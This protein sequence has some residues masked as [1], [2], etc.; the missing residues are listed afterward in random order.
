MKTYAAIYDSEIRRKSSSGGVFTVLASEILKKNGVVYGVA[1]TEDCYSAEFRKVT[2]VNDLSVFRGSKYFQA[3]MNNT[4]LQVK[5]DLLT[6]VNVL[7]SGTA[8]QIN[9]LKL[10]LGKEYDNLICVDV[11]CHGAPSPALWKKYIDHQE[12]LNGKIHTVNFRCKDH[13][14]NDFAMNENQ[15]YISKDK[16]PFMRM[17][18][19]DY[20]L[21]PSCYECLA[22]QE[23]NSDITIADFWGI[24]VVAPEMN[25]GKGTS[26]VITRTGKGRKLF[27][28]V[29]DKIKVKEV[30]YEEGV[31]KNPSD[32]K[33][34]RRP[35][36]RETFF[37]DMNSMSFSDLEKKYAADIEV[38]FIIR[39]KGKI[40][41]ILQKF[42]EGYKGNEKNNADYGILFTFSKKR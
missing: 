34:A 24:E 42:F 14:W 32:Y 41:L 3:K 22:K 26:L 6:G 37:D 23:K 11:I 9:G 4:F 19:R 25:D 15:L 20:C 28:S 40:K 2:E 21:R 1:M 5:Q 38:K 33:S 35:E 18:L 17:F 10:Y 7:F 30:S 31:M 8:C 13:S 12:E 29:M 39:V 27:E 36:Q 16:D